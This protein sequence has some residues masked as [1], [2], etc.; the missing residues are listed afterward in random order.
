MRKLMLPLLI[1]LGVGFANI[2][3]AQDDDA[4]PAPK[5]KK[6]KHSKKAKKAKKGDDAAAAP[7]GGDAAAPA[8][9]GDA[10]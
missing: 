3:V 6:A 9:G 10:K 5:A 7:A 4:K 8:A 2:A 1:V